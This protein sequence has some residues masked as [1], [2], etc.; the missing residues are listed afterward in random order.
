[1]PDYSREDYESVRHQGKGG[2]TR[3]QGVAWN[4]YWFLTA[5]FNFEEKACV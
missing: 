2:K 5:A 3:T 1:M 4:I